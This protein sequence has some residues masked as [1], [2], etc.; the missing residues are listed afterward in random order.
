M[1]TRTL[2][3]FLAL[4]LASP[5]AAQEQ[6][7]PNS[8][9]EECIDDP[10][11][12]PG[13]KGYKHCLHPSYQKVFTTSNCSCNNGQC[14]ATDWKFDSRSP[15]GVVFK[16]DGKWCPVAKFIDPRKTPVPRELHAD[17]AHVCVEDDTKRGPDGCPLIDQINCAI[18][19]DGF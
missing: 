14:R 13:D 10:N 12:K 1:R 3:I 5:V 17:P 7:T 19:N 11:L 9:D 2:M 8:A 18:R 15:S 4:S 6:H 16:I